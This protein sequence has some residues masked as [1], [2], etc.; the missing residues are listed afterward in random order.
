MCPPLVVGHFGPRKP[1]DFRLFRQE[2]S[3]QKVV[4]SGHQFSTREVTRCAEDN[5]GVRHQC[6][7]WKVR[8]VGL[9]A[10][11]KVYS[12]KRGFAENSAKVLSRS[13]F[14]LLD[15]HSS[16]ATIYVDACACNKTACIFA[17]KKNGSANEFVRIA[18]AIHRCLPH[19]L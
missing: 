13:C 7:F 8:R 4:K 18:K 9:E 12:F 2:P 1:N 16:K 10:V 14:P 6:V 5:K 11:Q 15:T 19:D 3:P 17:A